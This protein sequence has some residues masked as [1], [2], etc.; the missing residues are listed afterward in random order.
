MEFPEYSDEVKELKNIKEELKKAKEH[1]ENL[2]KVYEEVSKNLERKKKKSNLSRKICS[3]CYQNLSD[4][5]IKYRQ[6]YCDEC[7]SRDSC[8]DNFSDDGSI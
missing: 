4:E 8:L 5:E 1:Y 6:I 2:K 3:S 7:C